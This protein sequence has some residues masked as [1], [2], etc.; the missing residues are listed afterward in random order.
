MR[1]M[2][3]A[4]STSGTEVAGRDPAGSE[5]M[6]RFTEELVQAGVL[7]G[8]DAL[9]PSSKGA[10]VRFEGGRRTVIDGPFTAAGEPVAGYWIWQVRSLDEAI[11]WARRAPLGEGSEL[12]VREVLEPDD[13][14]GPPVTT[15]H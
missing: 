10:R 7:L 2:V 15:N 13:R 12:E 14:P 9:Q 1:V 11:E 3:L 5:A 8:A 6:G 4:R